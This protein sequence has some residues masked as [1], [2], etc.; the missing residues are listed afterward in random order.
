MLPSCMSYLHATKVFATSTCPKKCLKLDGYLLVGKGIDGLGQPNNIDVLPWVPQVIVVS[1]AP[2]LCTTIDA[3]ILLHIGNQLNHAPQYTCLNNH[4]R[5]L[6][7]LRSG[8]VNSSCEVHIVGV[9][10]MLTW[11]V[12]L[13]SVLAR[14]HS[15]KAIM[16]SKSCTYLP[17]ESAGMPNPKRND[18]HSLGSLRRNGY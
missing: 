13:S 2:I 14:N 1:H 4:R 16:V 11:Q 10:T 12:Y 8:N 9:C 7:C 3:C 18:I 17:S 6:V 5:L 15:S